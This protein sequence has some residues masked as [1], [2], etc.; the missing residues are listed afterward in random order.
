M[1]H[2]VVATALTRPGV[3]NDREGDLAGRLQAGSKAIGLD[4][5][6]VN[7][8]AGLAEKVRHNQ[9]RYELELTFRLLRLF[10]LEIALFRDYLPTSLARRQRGL[11]KPA[12]RVIGLA[13]F[14]PEW[15]GDDEHRC[16]VRDVLIH[17]CI[18][19]AFR[20]DIERLGGDMGNAPD[21]EDGCGHAI[22]A[23]PNSVPAFRGSVVVRSMICDPD[24]VADVLRDREPDLTL[25]RR[26]SRTAVYQR[27]SSLGVRVLST[28]MGV[29]ELIT[30]VD[31]RAD[32]RAIAQ[33]LMVPDP[34]L[35]MLTRAYTQLRDLRVIT[36]AVPGG[37]VCG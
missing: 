16:V 27:S 30:A 24:Q 14:A 23:T 7:D 37:S 34:Q 26:E 8:F 5:A 20:G 10:E 1:V 21:S 36:L 32:V 4:L 35:P 31:G 29:G 18:L 11:T 9:I 33:R 15:A 25:I 22:A 3:L 28:D 13:E 19:A 2:S 17:E 12:D 6:S